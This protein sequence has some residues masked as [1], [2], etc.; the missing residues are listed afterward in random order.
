MNQ[1]RK[2]KGTVFFVDILGFGALTQNNINLKKEDF[3]VWLGKYKSSYDNQDLAASILVKFR[4]ILL[5]IDKKFPSITISQLSDCAF[6]W[7]TD[8]KDVIIAANNIMSQCI[9]DGILCRGGLS[10]GEII[11]TGL[12]NHSLGRFI[13]GKAVTNAV[14]L[15]WIAKGCRVMINQEFVHD[16]FSEDETFSSHIYPLFQEFINP[17][18]FE[19]YDEFKWYFV[20]FMEKSFSIQNLSYKDKAKYTNARL[21]LANNIRLNP[22]F[23]WNATNQQGKAHLKSSLN[24]LS[25]SKDEIFRVSHNFHFIDIY[26]N[27]SNKSLQNANKLIDEEI[28]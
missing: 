26:D 14:K 18:D 9:T 7:S 25:E 19:I 15:E 23:S 1:L 2:I 22:L 4:E 6:I 28:V 5:S 11:E 12:N 24:F 21:K 13:L 3:S 16:L 20:P 8:M 10:F 27:R 17:L